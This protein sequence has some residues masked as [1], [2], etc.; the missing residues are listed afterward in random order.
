L[1]GPAESGDARFT[2]ARQVARQQKDYDTADVQALAERYAVVEAPPPAQDRAVDGE[3]S[4]VAFASGAGGHG[5]LACLEQAA[6]H[7]VDAG[8]PIELI[9]ARFQGTPAYLGVF[10]SGPGA[11]ENADMIT[12]WV[13]ASEDCSL[14]LNT[15][16]VRI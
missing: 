1:E 8:P 7:L 2:A 4:P 6:P 3:G 9:E 10:A 13:V 14:P 11:G 12:V 5:A 16:Q 15:T